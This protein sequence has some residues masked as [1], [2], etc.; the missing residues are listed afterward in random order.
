MPYYIQPLQRNRRRV[1]YVVNDKGKRVH[2]KPHRNK[3]DAIAHLNALYANV[4]DAKMSNSPTPIAR[5]AEPSF[6]PPKAVQRAAQQALKVRASKPPSQRGMTE[7]GLARA[8]D[9]AN[10]KPVSLTTVK[11]MKRYFDRHEVDKKGS[12]WSDKGKGWQSFAGWGGDAAKPFVRKILRQ[13][14]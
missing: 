8:R 1:F 6:T 9:L 13:N 2:S 11:R 12:T 14:S 4:P 7:V 3:G 10:G 5:F